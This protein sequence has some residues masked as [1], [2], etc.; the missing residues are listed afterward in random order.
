MTSGQITTDL[1]EIEAPWN[2]L[3]SAQNVTYE[4]GMS[5]IRFRIKEGKRFT[6]FELDPG[7]ASWLVE[8]LRGWLIDQPKD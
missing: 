5:M 7:T 8:L 6:D 3:I 1:G 4:G 2:K